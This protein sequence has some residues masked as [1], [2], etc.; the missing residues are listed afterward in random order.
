MELSDLSND[1]NLNNIRSDFRLKGEV[2]TIIV[3]HT[4]TISPSVIEKSIIKRVN[5][6]FSGVGL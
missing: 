4:E 1:S 3:N 2:V 5:T 6:L